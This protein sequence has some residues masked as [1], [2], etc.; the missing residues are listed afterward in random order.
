LYTALA[1]TTAFH[2]FFICWWR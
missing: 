2:L 1:F